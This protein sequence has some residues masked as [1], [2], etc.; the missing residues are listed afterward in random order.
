MEG[1]DSIHMRKAL[2][3]AS[4]E[5]NVNALIELLEEDHL[6]LER[7]LTSSSETPLH[8]AAMLSHVEFARDILSRKPDLTWEFDSEGFSPL[9]MASA[10]KNIDMVRELVRYAPD[11]CLSTDSDGRTPLHL[12]AMKGR[13]EIMK[14]LFQCRPEALDKVL[15]HG[16]D[17][18]LHLCV[19]NNRLEALELLLQWVVGS[20]I[21]VNSKDDH[22]N[23]ILHLAVAKKHIQIIKLLLLSNTAHEVE[24]NVLNQN[25]LTAL[26]VLTQSNVRDLK[27]ME[28]AEVLRGTG[29]LSATEVSSGTNSINDGTNA[30]HVVRVRDNPP[31]NH[32]TRETSSSGRWGKRLNE[33]EKWLEK[34]QST[35]M[36]VASLIASI[37]FQAIL[38]PPTK[39]SGKP[40][41]DREKQHVKDGFAPSPSISDSTDDNLKAWYMHANTIGVLGSM[42]V[43]L[44][45][46]SGLPLKRRVFVWVLM[47]TMCASMTAMHVGPS[48][49]SSQNCQRPNALGTLCPKFQQ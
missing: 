34:K 40:L 48:S 24:V 13:V 28:I 49:L 11:V 47:F 15:F 20:Q 38:N 25:G 35:V 9:H 33:Y 16:G 17:T 42:I 8:I 44:L 31:R 30:A 43:I 37:G 21:S 26:D 12:A 23:T 27:D 22:G 19:K 39:F 6:V 18:I 10:R 5:G 4:L 41:E 1:R 14:E 32:M 2:Y 29:G 46:M 36:V 7:T 45:V 3:K